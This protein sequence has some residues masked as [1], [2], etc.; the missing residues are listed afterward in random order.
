M[1]RAERDQRGLGLRLPQ[2]DRGASSCL[3]MKRIAKVLV[4]VGAV[5]MAAF[6]FSSCAST[7]ASCCGSDGSCCAAESAK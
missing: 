6:S 4:L 7:A 3:I 5:S 1:R 2:E